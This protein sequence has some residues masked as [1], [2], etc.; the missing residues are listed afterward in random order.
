MPDQPRSSKRVSLPNRSQRF[1]VGK[2]IG[3]AVYV[4][5][6]FESVFEV[7][8]SEAKQHVPVDFDYTVI[9]YNYV[10]GAFTFIQSDD[11][12]SVP[13]PTVGISLTVKQNGTVLRR[14]QLADPYIYHHK[15][16]FVDDNYDGFNVEQ[17]KQRSALWLSLEN[18]DK[19]KIG[20]LSYWKTH[21]VPRIE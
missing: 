8:L 9:K 3:G 7:L 15:W 12:D 11:F 2:E 5:R 1:G 20:R 16:L 14:K 21:V 19:R 17:S 6:R 10:N 18:V 13:E 4:H